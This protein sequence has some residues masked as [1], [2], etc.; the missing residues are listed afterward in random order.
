[1]KDGNF[2]EAE[3][4][5]ISEKM[6]LLGLDKDLDFKK[7]VI[8]Y[9]Q[10]RPMVNDEKEY[11]RHIIELISPVNDLALLSYCT[12]LMVSDGL[13]EMT[14]ET[15]VENIANALHIDETSRKTITKLAMQRKVI[16]TGKIV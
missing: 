14:E 4:N 11:L 1:M 6:V 10:Y 3:L 2:Q 9:Q 16:E 12:E 15:L 7:E 8:K 5:Q 13:L